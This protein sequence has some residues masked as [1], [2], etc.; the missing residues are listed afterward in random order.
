M[1][2]HNRTEQSL[3]EKFEQGFIRPL[4]GSCG[5]Q[6]QTLA[7]FAEAHRG[8]NL[9]CFETLVVGASYGMFDD[10][11]YNVAKEHLVSM[12]RSIVLHWHGIDPFAQPKRHQILLVRKRGRRGIV[13]FD[14]VASYVARRFEGVARVC[15]TSYLGLSIVEQMAMLAQTTVA[16]SPCGGLSMILPFLPEG[17][18]AILLNYMLKRNFFFRPKAHGECYGCSWTMETEFWNHMRVVNKMYYQVFRESDFE[19]GE[20]GRESAVRVNGARLA[21]LIRAALR[22]MDQ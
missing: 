18:Y 3:C 13:N 20:P 12:Y 7:Q 16:V 8:S 17:A 19:H 4:T 9:T 11:R 21:R 10:A 1:Y 5:A 15:R 14:E 22:E 6:L 2:A